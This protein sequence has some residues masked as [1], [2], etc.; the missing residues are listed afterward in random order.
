MIYIKDKSKCCRWNAC[1]QYCPK[2]CSTMHED[3]E[4]FLYFS[5]YIPALFPELSFNDDMSDSK[6]NSFIQ[7]F[8]SESRNKSRKNDCL[9]KKI[10]DLSD[11]LRVIQQ[12]LDKK[13][14]SQDATHT[15]NLKLTAQLSDQCAC[16]KSMQSKLQKSLHE[17]AKYRVFYELLR[18]EKFVGTSKKS[19]KSRLEAGRDN[20]KD[21]WDGKAMPVLM[22]LPSDGATTD[23]LEPPI[24]EERSNRQGVKYYTINSGAAILHKCDL[25]TGFPKAL[26]P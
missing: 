25:L 12:T 18:N 16:L 4:G 7:F 26:M 5:M 13:E 23:A 1:A 19:L 9:Q 11:R 6:K 14:S 24:K 20:D 3:E 10:D 8:V 15:E 22:S 2:L 21:E 17:A